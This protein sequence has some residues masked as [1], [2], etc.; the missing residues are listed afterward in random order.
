MLL[1]LIERD[2]CAAREVGDYSPRWPRRM[3]ASATSRFG[4]CGDLG[5]FLRVAPTTSCNRRQHTEDHMPTR[6]STTQ[7]RPASLACL[8]CRRTHLKCDGNTPICRRCQARGYQCTYTPSGRGRRRGVTRLNTATQSTASQS[9]P[10]SPDAVAQPVAT[11]A[12]LGPPPAP[13]QTYAVSDTSLDGRTSITESPRSLHDASL[14]DPT[15]PRLFQSGPT[16]NSSSEQF[17]PWVDDEQLVNLYYLN[18]HASHPILLPRNMYWRQNYP[19]YLKAVVQLIGSHFS[20]AAS[21]D[22][23]RE[24]AARE[25]QNGNQ[26]TPEMV[27]A[28]TLYAI[29]L[30]AQNALREVHQVLDSAIES[31]LKLGMHRRDFAV[32]HANGLAAVEESMRRTWYELYVTDGCIAALQ[33]KSTFR[34]NTVNADVLLPCDDFI[35]EGGMCF[36]PAT[37]HEFHSNVFA[38][39]EKVFSSFCYRIESVRLLGRVLSITGAHG[40]HRDLVQAVDNALAAFILHLP[41]SK[42]EAEVVNTFGELDELMFQTHTFI[43][44]STILLHFPRG[45]LIS[46]DSLTQDV[47]G[48]DCARLLCP[49]NR[50]HVHSIKAIEAS[51]TISMLAALRTPAQRHSPFFM[52]PIAL[53]AAVQLSVGAMHAR[54]SSGC[55][56]Q[57][58]DR[59][60]LMLGV[61]KSLGRHWSAADIIL[62]T[63]KKV[64]SAVF[65]SP[66]IEPSYTT[67]Q[68]ES[69]DSGTDTCPHIPIDSDWLDS[70]Y[71]QDLNGLIGLDNT[72]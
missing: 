45:D 24:R 7:V 62:R 19:R 17:S 8:E 11:Q 57:H 1:T 3:L 13:S 9:L 25:I 58:S 12:L 67:R 30:L 64:A 26:N 31:A 10:Y 50:Q 14:G 61:L 52:Y 27:Q 44:Y 69:M 4:L 18:F 51:K 70:F 59:I 56:E 5:L 29:A 55:V 33:R 54:I 36:M 72:T 20:P 63:L 48:G 41:R 37:L 68:D 66:R 15:Y 28:R 35:Y 21:R 47:P 23:L 32:A 65:R 60:K 46:P 49:C 40:V 53:A 22:V 34:T 6:G 43:Q 39:E 71:L 42:S 2:W 16:T 38:E